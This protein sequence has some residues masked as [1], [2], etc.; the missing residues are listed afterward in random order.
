[1]RVGVGVGTCAERLRLWVVAANEIGVEA[2]VGIAGKEIAPAGGVGVRHIAIVRLPD[3]GGRTATACNGVDL[4]I[5]LV[6]GVGVRRAQ[7]VSCT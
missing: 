3:G 6:A 5:A 7:R 2:D 4:E 1:M